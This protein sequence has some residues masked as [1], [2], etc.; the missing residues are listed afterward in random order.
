VNLIKKERKRGGRCFSHVRA[1]KKSRKTQRKKGERGRDFD[2]LPWRGE[3]VDPPS[4]PLKREKEGDYA[5]N[6]GEGGKERKANFR[7]VT[8]HPRQKK[9]A[10]PPPPQTQAPVPQKSSK[11]KSF[12]KN[13]RE[14]KVFI[15]FD[16]GR[17][18]KKWPPRSVMGPG[19]TIKI[20]EASSAEQGEGNVSTDYLLFL[21]ELDIRKKKSKRSPGAKLFF[22]SVLPPLQG[23]ES[24]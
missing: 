18:T 14:K 19:R 6:R 17:G 23:K 9:N 1:T 21:G 8:S 16:A 10:P 24:S 7:L 3:K 4:A 15:L 22:L 12:G 5:P 2:R 13:L 11:K 20:Y